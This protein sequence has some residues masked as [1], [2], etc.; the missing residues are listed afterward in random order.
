MSEIATE[1]LIGNP[2]DSCRECWG[3]VRVC[4]VQAIRVVNRRSEVIPQRCV[5]CGDCVTACGSGGHTVRDDLPRVAELLDSGRPVVAVLATE[6]LAAMHPMSFDELEWALDAAGFHGTE[7]TLLGEEMV[8]AVYEQLHAAARGWVVLRSTCPVATAWVTRYHPSLVDSLA[9]VVPPYIAQALLVKELYPADTAVVYVSPCYARKDEIDDPAF[10]GAVDVAIGFD[11]L[12]RL[13]AWPDAR[14]PAEFPAASRVPRPRLDKQISLT[15]GFPRTTLAA[16]DMT[17][18]DVVTVRGPER[19]GEL[20]GAIDRGETGPLIVDM[21]YCDGCV[22]GPA[23][24]SELSVYA[25]RRLFTETVGSPAA[26]PAGVDTRSVL[27]HLPALGLDRAFSASPVPTRAYSDEQIDACLA[28]GEFADRTQVLDCG[29]CGYDACI[30]HAIAVLSGDSSWDMCFPLE[31]KR[32]L[33]NNEALEESATLDPVTGLWNRR[34][35]SERLATEFARYQRYGA[36]LTLL[37]IDLDGFKAVN[38]GYGHTTGDAVLE[39][40]G[41][42]V[43]E[44]VR[45]TDIPARFGGDEFGLILPNV[46]KTAGYAVAEKLRGVIAGERVAVVDPD[47]EGEV[48]VTISVGLASAGPSASDAD[49]LLEAADRA[50]YRSKELGRDRVMIAPD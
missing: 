20:L 13:I 6:F 40:I 5:K 45:E 41:T 9:P 33:R 18:R 35:F 48:S 38:D 34:V 23:T 15:D 4:P 22:D 3:C 2:P 37:M 14:M 10:A 44:T 27:A 32:L 7:T 47:R 26:A 43:R 8:A 24:G 49:R 11:E 17:A 25:K 39:R 28:E 29:A 30:D 1:F 46:G 36:P 21:L 12:K 50:L 42:V 19:I 16:R 31:H